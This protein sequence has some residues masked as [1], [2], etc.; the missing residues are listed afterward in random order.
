MNF[1]KK[2]TLKQ[3]FKIEHISQHDNQS[4]WPT[5]NKLRKKTNPKHSRP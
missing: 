2:C 4:T 5:K 3:V 1:R